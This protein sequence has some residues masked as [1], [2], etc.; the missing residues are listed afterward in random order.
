MERNF[1]ITDFYCIEQN[2]LV[3]LTTSGCVYMTEICADS[4]KSL[5]VK[6]SKQVD[7]DVIAIGKCMKNS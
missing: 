3:Y 1:G 6:A 7:K 2:I 4:S 5:Q